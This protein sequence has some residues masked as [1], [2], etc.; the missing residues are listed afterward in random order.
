LENKKLEMQE[1]VEKKKSRL[2]SVPKGGSPAQR[3]KKLRLTKKMYWV[4]IRGSHK[5]TELNLQKKGGEN[6]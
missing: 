1:E 4:T 2:G 5:P 6:G 3:S